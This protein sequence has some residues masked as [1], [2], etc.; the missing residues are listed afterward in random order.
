TLDRARFADAE[1]VRRGAYVLDREP[2]GAPAPQLCLIA[3]GSEVAIAVAAAE[4]LRAGGARVRVVSMPC[5]RLFEQQDRAYRDAVLP[6]AVTA[7]IA[8]EAGASFGWDRYVG[9]GG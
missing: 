8:V 6:P 1:G 9:S 3:S 5:G 4:T 7:R 2:A